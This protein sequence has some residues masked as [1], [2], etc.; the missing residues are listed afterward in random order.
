MSAPPL[1]PDGRYIVVDG[2]L[3]RAA[4]PALPEA[5]RAA[6]IADLM[7]A[8]RAVGAATRSDDRRAER[9]ARDAVHAAKIAL[10]ERGPPWW[11][12]NAP[13]LNRHLVKNTD[14]AQWYA[15]FDRDAGT[16]P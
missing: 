1:T 14:Y 6:L 13:D 10:G 5:R 8:R 12:D 3:W 15:E 16:D 7:T 11:D 2:R 4:N 9:V